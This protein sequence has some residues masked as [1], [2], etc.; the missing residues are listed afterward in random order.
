M[1]LAE[2]MNLSGEPK[3]R[4]WRRRVELD[5]ERDEDGGWC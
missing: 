3:E 5:G 2:K 1:T 4:A